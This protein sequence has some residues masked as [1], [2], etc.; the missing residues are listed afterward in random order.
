[1]G[2]L[3]L[4][5]CDSQ[6][7]AASQIQL[8]LMDHGS[9]LQPMETNKCDP[10]GSFS[11]KQCEGSECKCFDKN[12]NQLG[13]FSYLRT[14]PDPCKCARDAITFQQFNMPTLSCDALGNY[15][16]LQEIGDY[17]FCVDTDGVKSSDV[18][19]IDAADLCIKLVECIGS[20]YNCNDLNV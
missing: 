14:I 10:D 4:R 12:M 7:K 17:L 20:S 2:S 9:Q 8:K 19:K 13:S 11:P 18:V 1:M 15:K 5:K 6:L 3:Y 16:S